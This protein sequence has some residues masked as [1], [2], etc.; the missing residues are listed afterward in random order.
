VNKVILEMSKKEQLFRLYALTE[1]SFFLSIATLFAIIAWAV[2]SYMDH[3]PLLNT[4]TFIAAVLNMIV[5][6]LITIRLKKLLKEI[7]NVE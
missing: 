6:V 2:N 3:V 4:L 7:G 5:I 1:K